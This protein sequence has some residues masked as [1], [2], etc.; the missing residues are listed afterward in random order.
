MTRRRLLAAIGL[1]LFFAYVVLRSAQRGNDFKYP[2]LAAQALWRTSRLHVSAQ[3]RYPVSFHVLLAPLASLPIGLASTVWAALS[4][5]AVGALPRIFERLSGLPFRQQVPAWFVVLPFFIDALVLGQSDPIN[6][7]LVSLGLLALLQEKTMVSVALV[8]L[9]GMVKILPILHWATIVARART[10]RVWLA[11]ALTASLGLG[12][13]VVAVGWSSALAAIREQVVWLSNYEKP[14]HLV[15]RHADLRVNNESL[16]IVLVRTFGDLGANDPLHSLSLGILSLD[17]IWLI[18]GLV[19]AGLS[20]AWIVCARNT[21]AAEPRRATLGVFALTSVV[22]LA[23]TPIC[24]H[25][26]FL[27][28]LPAVM[29]LAHRRRLLWACG[30]LSLVGTAIPV[31]RGLGCHMLMALGLFAVV[32]YDLLQLPD[33]PDRSRFN[34]F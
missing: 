13:I 27:W 10:W 12:V 6:V 7:C 26:Y 20:L 1:A 9:A 18:W 16:P 17:R 21:K 30:T 23:G 25:H 28:L 5:A 34:E 32:A 33:D 4:F 8:G 2:Y 19:L 29:F 24:W 22:M 15:A 3:P 14:W 11:M 31:A